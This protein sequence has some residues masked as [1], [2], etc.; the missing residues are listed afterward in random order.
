MK[1]VPIASS[2]KDGNELASNKVVAL[3]WIMEGFTP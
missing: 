2:L 3:D 1:Y